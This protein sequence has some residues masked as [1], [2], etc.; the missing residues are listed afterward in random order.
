[1]RCMSHRY[2]LIRLYKTGC[3]TSRSY[4]IPPFNDQENVQTI[5]SDIAILLK[6]WVEDAKRPQ[7]PLSRGDFPVDLL[8]RTIT[9]YLEELRPDRKETQA[10]F[11]DLKRQ[12]R[13]Y[14]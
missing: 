11:E 1:M 14:W 6:D 5:S 4:Q 8:D 10:I 12:L 13:R 2:V 7:S 9:K 3:R